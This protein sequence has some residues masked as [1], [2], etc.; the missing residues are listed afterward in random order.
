MDIK[1]LEEMGILGDIRERLGAKGENDTS[2]DTRITNMDIKESVAAWSAWHLGDESW[3]NDIIGKY[4]TLHNQK[5]SIL[6]KDLEEEIITSSNDGKVSLD[7]LF[8]A[9]DKMYRYCKSE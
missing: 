1:T 5:L 7:E 2:R 8:S 3:A 6:K 4:Q 9:L